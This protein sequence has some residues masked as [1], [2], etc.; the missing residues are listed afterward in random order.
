MSWLFS[1]ALV[2]EF[3]AATSWAGAPSAPLNVMPMP[4][5]FWR[6]DKM[7]EPSQLSRFGL[8]CALLTE[9]RGAELLTWFLAGFRART[10]ALQVRAQE[11]MANA[12][13]S[14][15]TRPASGRSR[16]RKQSCLEGRTAY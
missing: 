2:A 14:G 4:Q 5:Q 13:V 3:S 11:L 8:T 10:S 1:R 7:M 16:G 12:P 15:C 6:N 9:D